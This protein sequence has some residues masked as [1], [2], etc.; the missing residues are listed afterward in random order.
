M[1]EY[2]LSLRDYWRILRKRKGVVF[3]TTL[4]LGFFSFA[5]A[6]MRKPVPMYSATASVKYEKTY[7]FTG[8]YLET[9]SWSSG[10]L[11]TQAAIIRSYPVMERAA[12][13]LGYIDP[14]LTSEQ[15]RS[16][17]RLMEIVLRLQSKISTE[18]EGY[19]NIINITATSYNPDEA[20]RLAN[21][22]AEAYREYNSEEK[23]K[24]II[25]ARRFIEQQ[26]AKKKEE[27]RK[28]EDA[29]RKFREEHD[30]ISLD[31][32]TKEVISELSKARSEYE[33]LEGDIREISS[34][35]DQ[36]RRREPLSKEAMGLFADRVSGVFRSL[37][38][39]LVSLRVQRATLL[40]VYTE[41]HPKV[42]QVD[43]E[44][45]NVSENMIAELEAQR[46]TL[47]ERKE[48]VAR[49]LKRL[50]EEF[51]AL[52]EEAQTLDKLQHEVDVIKKVVELLESKYQE[53]L[54][55][56]SEKVEEVSIVKPALRP[57]HP[58]NPPRTKAATVAG[59]VM[60]LVL[61]VVFAFI[62]ESLDTSIGTIEDVEKYLGVPVLGIIPHMTTEEIKRTL[63]EEYIGKD[64]EEVLN[65]KARL[66]SHFAPKSALA[67]SFR[68]LRTSV[69]FSG[70]ERGTKTI[71]VT[72]SSR[73][74]GK[75]TV[76]VNLALVMAQAGSRVLLVEG[77]MR[78]PVIFQIFGIERSPG[79]SEVILGSHRWEEVV[80]T[81]TD[82]MMGKIKAEDILAVPGMDNLHIITCGTIPPNPAELFNFRRTDEFIS[83]VRERYDVVIFDSPPVLPVTDT[84]ILGSKVDGVVMVYRVGKI[85]R[86]ALRRAKVQ[87]DGANAKVL[88]VVLNGLRPEVS[89]DF[90]G[91]KYSRY[92]GYGKEEVSWWKRPFRTPGFLYRG[93]RAVL[94]A[95]RGGRG[96]MLWL[97]VVVVLPLLILGTGF[98]RQGEDP[99]VAVSRRTV[100]KVTPAEGTF[101]VRR[102]VFR[103][104]VRGRP[105][106]V[107]LSSYRHLSLANEEVDLLRRRGYDAFI[108][109]TH[110]PGKGLF[111]RV[112]IGGFT[113][114]AEARK[115]ANYLKETDGRKYAGV[116][117]L[118]YA[119]L[120]GS[121]P[122]EEGLGGR[123]EKLRTLGF[124]PY[125]TVDGGRKYRILLG[126]F[127]AEEEAKTMADR[128]KL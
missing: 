107:H 120:L 34:M 84:V 47:E 110:I 6:N 39:R 88:G 126:A 19:T 48:L 106:V 93:I 104:T 83:Q 87:L 36:L 42:R 27:L 5:F 82:V 63:L 118:P 98:L 85:G 62:V 3:F 49:K 60:G 102:F 78:V 69:Q 71:V 90:Q 105:Y 45:E 64:D 99:R 22:V 112:L 54:I 65:M 121:F 127:A 91:Y 9:M 100:G 80:R 14:N 21:A 43:S 53:A 77:D 125:L 30:L 73:G 124:F 86:G 26:L 46:R 4:A 103:T 32:K 20:Q 44:I 38:D 119:I 17:E 51:K 56:E 111:Y 115:L 70:L 75:T 79:L 128:L 11:E 108:A 59:L 2:T 72:S 29:V 61:G 16:D 67:E 122:P 94:R 23:N 113:T 81:V 117:K 96:T 41:K 55:K 28:A 116:L 10:G 74:G 97:V 7:T 25:E 52:P 13:K 40:N 95:F 109:P 12:K 50:E 66:I 114:E 76:A 92:Y 57:R 24:R 101:D 1:P 33:R 37:N 18:V 15:I 31:S 58:I 89:P 123:A 35:I 8:L 68:A